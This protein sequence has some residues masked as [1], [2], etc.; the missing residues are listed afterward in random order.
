MGQGEMRHSHGALLTVK[1]K[2]HSVLLKML[3]LDIDIP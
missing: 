3:V 1:V 2:G